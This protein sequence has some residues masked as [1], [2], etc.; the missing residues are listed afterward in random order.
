MDANVVSDPTG[1]GYAQAAQPSGIFSPSPD[2]SLHLAAVVAD[3]AT[4]EAQRL[5]ELWQ[6][7]CDGRWTVVGSVFT[8]SRCLFILRAAARPIPLSGLRLRVLQGVLSGSG[9]KGVGYELG[10]APSTVA[11]HARGALD[12][13]GIKDRPGHVSPLLLL[14]ANAARDHAVPAGVRMASFAH[15]GEAFW[16]AGALRPDVALSRIPPAEHAVVR[17]LVEGQ[18]YDEIARQ[19]GRSVRTI[20]NQLAAVFRKLRVSGR[21]QLILA[22]YGLDLAAASGGSTGKTSISSA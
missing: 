17:G 3:H 10:L 6:Q 13:L 21:C 4:R 22:L 5:D 9:Q 7:L 16:V 18:A 8:A 2:E 15:Q 14:A 11:A 19:R 12:Q 20:A 1:E